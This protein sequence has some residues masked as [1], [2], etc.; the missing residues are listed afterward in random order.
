MGKRDSIRKYGGAARHI[1]IALLPNFILIVTLVAQDPT[2]IAGSDACQECHEAAYQVLEATK[3]QSSYRTFHTQ[4]EVRAILER[5]GL[6]SAR[7]AFCVDCHYTS[8]Q[9]EG[10]RTARTI[11]GVSCESCHSPAADWMDIHNNY[12]R[13]AGGQRAT[14]E[15]ETPDHRAS[16]LEETARLGM[17]RP[18]QP[19]LLAQNCFQ[20]H[21]VPREELV[22]TGE[23]AA[24][25]DFELV[26]RLR[27]EVRHNFELSNDEVNRDA[28][29]DYDPANRNRVFYVLGQMLD[30]EYALRGLAEATMSGTYAKAMTDRA[31]T[32][33]ERLRAIQ[34][35]AQ[36]IAPSIQQ[37]LDAANQADLAPN[38]N[39]PLVAAADQI[40]SVAQAFAAERDGSALGSLDPL[41]PS[42]D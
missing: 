25:S 3:H 26:S 31:A 41:L 28:A 5:L 11:A 30:L 4:D 9:A 18:D 8:Q 7:R 13:D 1:V 19:Y 39:G 34:A 24:G 38:N 29:R 2:K 15:T 37:I 32:A 23:H 20:C 22:N 40:R 10:R 12:G 17:L 14:R 27:D 36:V 42:N 35:A 33:M 6:R 21:T 16:R